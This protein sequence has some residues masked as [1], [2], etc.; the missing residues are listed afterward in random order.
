MSNRTDDGY[1]LQFLREFRRLGGMA[2]TWHYA[3]LTTLE[4]ADRTKV[5]ALLRKSD[6]LLPYRVIQC[7]ETESPQTLAR[8]V[9]DELSKRAEGAAGVASW[10]LF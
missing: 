9:L 4:T 8:V 7:A 10:G 1:G 3:V 2:S 6:S 5:V